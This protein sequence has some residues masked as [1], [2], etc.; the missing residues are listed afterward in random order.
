[1][2]RKSANDSPASVERETVKLSLDA[3]AETRKLTAERRSD[4]AR[5]PGR[6]TSG[7]PPP[8]HE[9]APPAVLRAGPVRARGLPTCGQPRIHVQRGHFFFPSLLTFRMSSVVKI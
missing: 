7:S 8:F 2:A 1:V 3:G 9:P 4:R 5:L 6:P